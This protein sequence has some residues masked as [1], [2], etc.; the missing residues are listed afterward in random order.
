MHQRMLEL[1]QQ[2]ATSSSS[3]NSKNPAEGDEAASVA[4][5][6]PTVS[7]AQQLPRTVSPDVCP[8]GGDQDSSRQ[9]QQKQAQQQHKQPGGTFTALKQDQQVQQKPTV[10]S[11]TAGDVLQEP[12]SAST[13]AQQGAGVNQQ[14]LQFQRAALLAAGSR[15]NDLGDKGLA[16]L[17]VVLS[18]AIAA[19]LLKKV[20]TA[21]NGGYELFV[22]M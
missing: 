20:M 11:G 15:P 17:A 5:G 18:V 19:V 21:M 4:P 16:F 14:Q 12:S 2:A 1:Q 10:F 8:D 13:T 22:E 9:Q 6:S 7:A 3:N